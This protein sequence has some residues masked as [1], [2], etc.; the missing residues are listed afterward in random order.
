MQC[1]EG[2]LA[3]IVRSANNE[4][5]GLFV[6]VVAAWSPRPGDQIT[7]IPDVDLWLCRAKGTL[8][9]TSIDGRTLKVKEGPIPDAVLR[10]IR[11]HNQVPVLTEVLDLSCA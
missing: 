6:D 7:F 5:I 10:P 9:Y 4:N 8:T 1:K 3:V 2:D 11:P